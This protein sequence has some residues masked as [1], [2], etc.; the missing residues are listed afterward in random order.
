MVV[1][2]HVWQELLGEEVVRESVDF[3]GQVD[4]L[5][6]AFENGLAAHDAGVVYEDGGIA[7]GGADGGGG[8]GDGVGG[9][10]VA[11]EVADGGGRCG[12]LV[13]VS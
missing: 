5:F 3:E 6:C 2:D 13:L 11:F 10:E 8:G 4:V 1:G 9:G 7:E 12:S